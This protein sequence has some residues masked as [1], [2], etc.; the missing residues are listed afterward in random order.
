VRG[1]RQGEGGG[2]QGKKG[3]G[4]ASP[5]PGPQC[6]TVL[7]CGAPSFPEGGPALEI[8]DTW[9]LWPS[10]QTS[11]SSLGMSTPGCMP[12]VFPINML[13][14]SGGRCSELNSLLS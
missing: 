2:E 14:S 8:V 5:P 12:C 3:K 4:P 10:W 11:G 13:P 7:Q 1:E 9:R 6:D